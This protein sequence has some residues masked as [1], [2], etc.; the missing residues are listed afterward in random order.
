[1]F[2][3]LVMTNAAYQATGRQSAAPVCLVATSAAQGWALA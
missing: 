1:L 2:E 3:F